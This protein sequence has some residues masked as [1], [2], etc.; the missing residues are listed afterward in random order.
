MAA[1]SDDEKRLEKAIRELGDALSCGAVSPASSPWEVAVG[2]LWKQRFKYEDLRVTM[3]LLEKNDYMFSFD[4]K[5]GYHHVD[6]AQEH[7]KYLGFTWKGHYYVFTVLPFGLSSACYIFTKLVRPMVGYWRAKGLRIIV[8]LDDGLCAV[9]GE[10][11]A[12]E[13]SALVKST[14]ENAGFMANV[15]K[16]VWTPTQRLHWLGFVVDLSKGHIEVPG[17]RIKALQRK[18]ESVSRMETLCA[19]QLASVI[20]TIISMS[21][22]IGTVSRFMTRSIYRLL[23]SRISWWDTLTITPDAHQELKFWRAC[24]TDYNSQ[25]IWHSPSAVRVVYSDASDTGFGGYVVEH[26]ACVA[27]GQWTEHEARKSSTWRE[28]AAVLN[29]LLAVATK[30]M[31][32][33]LLTIG[34]W[35]VFY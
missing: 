34:T 3:L 6:I 15:E 35:P 17:E 16:S 29:V 28:L 20:G 14:L 21:L 25:P 8:Y 7:W 22:A 12:L 31:S 27:Y 13:A 26:G 1:D 32:G 10:D 9:A 18:L 23:E 19:R 4:L 30:L 24:L 11:K 5:S 2:F 33:G